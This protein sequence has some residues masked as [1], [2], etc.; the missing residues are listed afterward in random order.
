MADA[1]FN[2]CPVWR[3]GRFGDERGDVRYLPGRIA[4]Y[5]RPLESTHTHTPL[6]E[7]LTRQPCLLSWCSCL[8]D[9]VFIA[10]AL[11]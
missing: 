6:S 7:R 10:L 4:V 5:M 8:G 1:F 3:I 9:H 2:A 11:S